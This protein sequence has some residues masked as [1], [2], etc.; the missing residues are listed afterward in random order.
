MTR[1]SVVAR[2]AK[3]QKIVERYATKRA[4]LRKKRFQILKTH[5][6]KRWLHLRNCKSFQGMQVLQ[7]LQ[8]D[9]PLLEDR[10]LFT[11][12]LV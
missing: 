1:K 10:M 7:E 6:K 8:E 5:M 9:A 2:D 12:N 11:E 4:T 3:R